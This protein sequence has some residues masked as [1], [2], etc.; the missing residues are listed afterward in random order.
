MAYFYTYNQI[1]LTSNKGMS[2]TPGSFGQQVADGARNRQLHP[3]PSDDPVNM[4]L[5]ANAVLMTSSDPATSNMNTCLIHTGPGWGA[6][7]FMA[8]SSDPMHTVTL[9][10]TDGHPQTS[11]VNSWI[12]SERGGSSIQFRVPSNANPPI[13]TSG[14]WGD[15]RLNSVFGNEV[16]ETWKTIRD[17]PTELTTR[18]I[19]RNRLDRYSMG[20]N[21]NLPKIDGGSP[22]PNSN[23]ASGGHAWGNSVVSGLIRKHEIETDNPH[24]PHALLFNVRRASVITGYQQGDPSSPF[25]NLAFT[26]P[27]VASD[28]GY[29]LTYKY[30][31]WTDHNGNFVDANAGVNSGSVRMG[32]RFALDPAV[33]TDTYINSSTSSLKVR[34]LIRAARDYGVFIADE[35]RDNCSQFKMDVTVSDDTLYEVWRGQG[36]WGSQLRRVAGR[37]TPGGSIVHVVEYS[38]WRQWADAGQG[39]GGGSPRVPYS[40]PLAPL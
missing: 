37:M 6:P 14:G 12:D 34:A 7:V 18:K 22:Y 4:P 33:W 21:P 29:N 40:P 5:G 19:V 2:V 11:G 8:T 20:K 23:E 36:F 1:R 15:R 10:W 16:L 39:W 30:P 28:G 17:S 31:S 35:T 3:N 9:G 24:I 27:A 38:H 32:M 13:P 26:F 25:Y